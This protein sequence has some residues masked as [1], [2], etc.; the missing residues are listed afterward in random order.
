MKGTLKIPWKTLKIPN[1]FEKCFEKICKTHNSRWKRPPVLALSWKFY[2]IILVV[3]LKYASGLQFSWARGTRREEYTMIHFLWCNV[4]VFNPFPIVKKPYIADY[5][6]LI[7]KRKLP[8]IFCSAT[9]CTHVKSVL[10]LYTFWGGIEMEHGFKMSQ[11]VCR[12][13]KNW[14]KTLDRKQ[15]INLTKN[16]NIFL[17]KNKLALTII[18][19]LKPI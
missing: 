2:E 1:N 8:S 17:C 4:N 5:E 13:V 7:P 12:G 3:P 9:I 16:F 6:K 19:L 10:H 14:L 11:E 15:L 18:L